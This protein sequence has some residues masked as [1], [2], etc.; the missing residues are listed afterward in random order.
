M[1]ELREHY[2][3]P[4]EGGA[5]RSTII[6]IIIEEVSELPAKSTEQYGIKTMFAPSLRN[7]RE[8]V[9]YNRFIIDLVLTR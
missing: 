6:F 7:I 9:E 3:N 4:Q 8:N 1:Y 2:S 5:G